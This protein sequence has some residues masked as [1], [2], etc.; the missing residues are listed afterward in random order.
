MDNT[1][2]VWNRTNIPGLEVRSYA[3]TTVGL[4]LWGWESILPLTVLCATAPV[5]SAAEPA[6]PEE[7]SVPHWMPAP[8][9]GVR[10][11]GSDT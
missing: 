8:E 4:R 3:T 2:S 5:T 9:F 10:P 7:P 1:P 6:A 11:Q